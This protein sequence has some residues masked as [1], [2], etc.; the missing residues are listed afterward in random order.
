M[1]IQEEGAKI[2][3]KRKEALDYVKDKLHSLFNK[4]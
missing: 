3:Q 2:N 1:D 4:D